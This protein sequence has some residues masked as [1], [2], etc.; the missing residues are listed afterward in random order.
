M[1]AE[2]PKKDEQVNHL[3]LSSD[4]SL[5]AASLDSDE[6][7]NFEAEYGTEA[8]QATFEM[9][10]YRAHLRDPVPEG[11]LRRPDLHQHSNPRL[12]LVFLTYQ[13]P[14][15]DVTKHQTLINVSHIAH[16]FSQSL[17]I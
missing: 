8:T 13:R 17:S 12:T 9:S 7:N 15:S 16:K 2:A 3:N 6:V 5:S 1:S 10:E 11:F 4:D 14:V